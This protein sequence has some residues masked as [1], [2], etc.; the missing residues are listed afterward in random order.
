MYLSWWRN[1]SKKNTTSGLVRRDWGLNPGS[2][3]PRQEGL[4]DTIF[5]DSLCDGPGL[6]GAHVADTA[7]AF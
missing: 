6:Q 5:C 4:N 2:A 7:K 1:E 3:E